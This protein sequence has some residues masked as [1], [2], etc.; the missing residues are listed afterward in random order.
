MDSTSDLVVYGLTCGLWVHFA[1]LCR[2]CHRSTATSTRGGGV[3]TTPPRWPQIKCTSGEL[4]E[5]V[6]FWASQITSFLSLLVGVYTGTQS[7]ALIPAFVR[8]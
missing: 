3:T 7:R 2:A 8:A 6:T 5:V 1:I 4:H